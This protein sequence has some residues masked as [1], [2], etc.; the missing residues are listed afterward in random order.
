MIEVCSIGHILRKERYRDCMVA[1]G[2]RPDHEGRRE[3]GKTSVEEDSIGREAAGK[4]V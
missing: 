2:W 1:L 4:V 3:E